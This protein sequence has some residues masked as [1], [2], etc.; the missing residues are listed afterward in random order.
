MKKYGMILILFVLLLFAGVPAAA[1]AETEAEELVTTVVTTIPITPIATTIP[2]TEVPTIP[3][4]IV[5]TVPTTEVTTIPTTVVTTAPTTEVTTVPPT[6]E[7]T[8]TVTIPDTIEPVVEGTE[9]PEEV[10]TET[11]VEQE[12][13][14]ETTFPDKPTAETG[15]DWKDFIADVEKLNPQTPGPT[16]VPEE[17]IPSVMSLIEESEE[18]PAEVIVPTAPEYFSGGTP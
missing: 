16:P 10:P 11:P 4:T 17:V 6:V 3:T 13:L 18:S 7:I 9:E 5:T 1:G 14:E 2:T 15:L 12:T 8:V